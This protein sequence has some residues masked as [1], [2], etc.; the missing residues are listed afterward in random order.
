MKVTRVWMA[1]GALLCVSTLAFG[2]KAPQVKSQKEGEAIQAIMNAGT[3]DQKIAAVENL[4]TKYADTEYKA[5]ALQIAT[6]AAREKNDT[7]QVIIYGERTLEVDPKNYDAMVTMSNAIASRVKKF[8]LDKAE[9]LTRAEKLANDAIPLIKAAPKP[10]PQVT[11]E[12]W[13]GAKKDYLAEAYQALAL[14][15]SGREK[16]DDAIKNMKAAVDLGS[17]QTPVAMARLAQVYNQAGKYDDAIATADKL[18]GD[19]NAQPGVKE[20][21]KQQKEMATKAKGGK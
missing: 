10:N 11:D 2:Q 5:I 20:F 17:A 9:K 16:Y 6:N 14:C 21:A 12:Q 13:E 18:M 8:D 15:A 1:A 3:P 4:L 19:A 7:D